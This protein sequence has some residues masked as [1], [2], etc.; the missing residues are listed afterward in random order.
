MPQQPGG[1]VV[2]KP[3]QNLWQAMR[4]NAPTG[5]WLQR[6]ENGVS[7]GMA[8]VLC[9]SVA[10]CSWLELKEPKVPVYASSKLFT[11]SSA[12]R[13]GQINWHLKMASL[14]QRTYVLARGHGYAGLLLIEGR[15]ADLVNGMSVNEAG[16][17]SLASHWQGVWSA[18]G[19]E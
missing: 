4:R 18:I 16:Q 19:V 6:I 12:L 8:D 3:E 10:G 14:E 7:E 1:A 11:G 15:Y 9:V 2:R 17:Y 13:Q 5:C